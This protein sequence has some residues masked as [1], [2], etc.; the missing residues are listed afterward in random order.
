VYATAFSSI[1]NMGLLTR[2][3]TLVLPAMYVLIAIDPLRAERSRST[4][5]EGPR[6]ATT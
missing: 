4:S 5:R 6:R 3:R 1:A 2:Q